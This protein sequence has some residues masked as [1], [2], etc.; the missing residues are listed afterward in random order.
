MLALHSLD[1]LFP[2]SAHGALATT[3][4]QSFEATSLRYM[5]SRTCAPMVL[6]L[7]DW[8]GWVAGVACGWLALTGGDAGSYRQIT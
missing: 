6:L 8:E 7:G 4:C 3:L 5:A 2:R 1:V